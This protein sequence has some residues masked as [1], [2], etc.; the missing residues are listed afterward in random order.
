MVRTWRPERDRRIL[1]VLD[2]GRTSAGELPASRRLD[3]SMDA[4]LLL[5]ALRP[6]PG[7]GST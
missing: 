3:A 7:T 2:T 4:T 6:G 1:I 5:T